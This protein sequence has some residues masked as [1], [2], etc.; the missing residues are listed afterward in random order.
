[1]IQAAIEGGARRAPVVAPRPDLPLLDVLRLLASVAV[2]RHHMRADFLFGVAFGL[3]LFLLIMFGL[4]ASSRKTEPLGNFVRRK[5]S[6]LLVPWLRWSCI[7]F[8]VLG[9]ADL[10]RGRSFWG[11]VEPGMVFYGGEPS[12]WFLPFAA[13]AMLPLQAMQRAG[14]RLSPGRASLLFGALG[15]G[16]TGAAAWALRLPIPEVPVRSWLRVAPAIFWGLALGQSVRCAGARERGL[17]LSSVSLLALGSCALAEFGNPAEDLPRRFAVATCLA[18]IGF[19]WRPAVPRAVRRLSTA[20]F[21]VYLVHPLV[22]K[23]LGGAFDVFSWPASVHAAAA[24]TLT[25]LAVFALQ[26][27]PLSWREL[28]IAH[29]SVRE[30]PQASP[31][32]ERRAA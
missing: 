31:A 17:V 8:V 29:G 12:L 18:S 9:C 16:A 11:R 10:A 1:M 6:F 19:G 32:I 27:L 20:T 14:A 3:P 23:L 24:W 22:G 25:A 21:G 2:V 4:A 15:L 28:T 26:R 13:A 30:V 7:Y 5:T